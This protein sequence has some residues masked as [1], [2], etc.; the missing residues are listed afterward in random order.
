MLTPSTLRAPRRHRRRGTGAVI[1]AIGLGVSRG[2]NGGA[3]GVP[4][5]IEVLNEVPLHDS[6]AGLK[7]FDMRKKYAR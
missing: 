6:F 5:A 7:S 3:V 1:A 2:T 4:E